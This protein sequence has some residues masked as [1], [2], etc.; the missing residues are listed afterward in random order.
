MRL[1]ACVAASSA[2][3]IAPETSGL[4]IENPAYAFCSLG[5]WTPAN[6]KKQASEI[7][8]AARRWRAS[9]GRTPRTQSM[10]LGS[11][12]ADPSASVPSSAGVTI[13]SIL[14]PRP[15]AARE[16]I[17]FR[18][19]ECR[20]RHRPEW[21]CLSRA[22]PAFASLK[23]LAQGVEPGGFNEWRLSP[24]CATIKEWSKKNAEGLRH[25][26]RASPALSTGGTRRV[27]R[28]LRCGP[29]PMKP[30]TYWTW[31][32]ASW[33][34]SARPWSASGMVCPQ[35]FSADSSSTLRRVHH[36]TPLN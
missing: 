26:E 29:C 1:S 3:N 36:A 20:I 9:F 30:A 27:G 31:S 33:N 10:P 4:T 12:Q 11:D 6:S 35:S 25:R 17:D 13:R 2:F 5:T 14:S 16:R 23:E 22:L 28:Q 8:Q 21:I 24:K 7:T 32:A 15:Q 18:R 34:V 19:I